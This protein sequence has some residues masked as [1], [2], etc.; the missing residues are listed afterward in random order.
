[1]D[2][3][4]PP[5]EKD[6]LPSNQPISIEENHPITEEIAPVSELVENIENSES[7]AELRF[8]PTS[9]QTPQPTRQRHHADR[10]HVDVI[11]RVEDVQNLPVPISLYV[12]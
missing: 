8:T 4:P 3:P 5:I 9:S 6:H 2:L 11:R 12:S 1:M 10:Q 7:F